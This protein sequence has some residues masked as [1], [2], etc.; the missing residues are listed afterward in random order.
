MTERIYIGSAVGTKPTAQ[1]HNIQN[2]LRIYT[3]AS[4]YEMRGKL[5]R[6]MQRTAPEHSYHFDIIRPLDDYFG[7]FGARVLSYFFQFKDSEL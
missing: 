7:K 4:E 6:A 1:G 2:I 3:A 5:V